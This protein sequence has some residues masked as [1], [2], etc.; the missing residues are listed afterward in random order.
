[1]ILIKVGL[2]IEILLLLF[3]RRFIILNLARGKIDL[4]LKIGRVNLE[5]QISLAQPSR[6][7][8]CSMYRR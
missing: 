3:Q 5:K 1:M 6:V 4:G 7:Q 8:G 2:P